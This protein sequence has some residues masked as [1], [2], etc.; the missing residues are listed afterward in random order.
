M[1]KLL[2]LFLFGGHV[3]PIH[4]IQGYQNVSKCRPQ[5]RHM[6]NKGKQFET[7]FFIYGP[8]C[9][10]IFF[11]GGGP[12]G[13]QWSD[14]AYLAFQLTSHPY[15]CACQIRTQSDKKLERVGCP[16]PQSCPPA[17]EQDE[18]LINEW[19]KCDI[20]SYYLHVKSGDSLNGIAVISRTIFVENWL[21]WP[22]C[23]SE[24]A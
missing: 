21:W 3:G 9:K 18:M 2:L 24:I 22:S 12:G 10:T 4:K 1:K 8:K 16:Q 13:L 14:W 23:F 17:W 11:W 19:R 20:T 7:Q 5:W 6:Y 15:L